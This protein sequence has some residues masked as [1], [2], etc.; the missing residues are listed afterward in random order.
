M[1]SPQNWFNEVPSF[2]LG[3][4]SNPEDL[5]LLV[6]EDSLDG[7][8]DT[9][10][11]Q[12][13]LFEGEVMSKSNDK[14]TTEQTLV[15]EDVAFG[16]QYKNNF[17]LNKAPN[18]DGSYVSDCGEAQ[19]V[20]QSGRVKNLRK[21]I[22]QPCERAFLDL[23]MENFDLNEVP[24]ETMDFGAEIEELKDEELEN[25]LEIDELDDEELKN[26]LEIEKLDDEELENGL[27]IEALDDE[28]LE[29]GVEFEELNDEELE[30]GLE[31]EE[32]KNEE[33]QKGIED[34]LKIYIDSMN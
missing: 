31:I 14:V 33:L 30:N 10:L 21:K 3:I 6:V 9:N 15:F 12:D 8:S 29:N 2:D 28:E 26:G 32:L 13:T 19:E 24:V 4:D 27:E 25:G 23:N 7:D 22:V 20:M 1:A 16:E 34:V 11:I 18:E 17:D 5:S